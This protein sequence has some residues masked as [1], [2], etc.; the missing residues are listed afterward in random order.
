MHPHHTGDFVNR[1]KSMGHSQRVR[2][3]RHI[4]ITLCMKDNKPIDAVE[5]SSGKE[6]LIASE[7]EA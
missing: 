3:Q 4:Q 7:T 2:E 6:R 1:N 5:N